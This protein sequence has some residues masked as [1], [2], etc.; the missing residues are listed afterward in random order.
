MTMAGP[1]VYSAKRLT[2]QAREVRSGDDFMR[3]DGLVLTVASTSKVLGQIHLRLGRDPKPVKLDPTKLVEI[4][5]WP[6]RKGQP[7]DE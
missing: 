7:G 4:M 5:R 2:V 3:D 1:R 6:N